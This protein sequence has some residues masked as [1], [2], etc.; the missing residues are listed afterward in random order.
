VDL[1]PEFAAKLGAAFGAL[2]K[3]GSVVTVN[4]DLN[5]TSRMIKRA[6]IAGLPSS[7]VNV[8]DL[9][10][11][12]IPVA[13]YYTHATHAVG[14]VHV[15]L[16]PYDRRVVDIKFFNSEGLT[17]DKQTERTVERI[18]FR[19]DF[20]R[21]YLDDIGHIENA[22]DVSERYSTHFCRSL[23]LPAIRQRKFKLVVDY[24]H[25]PVSLV[26]PRLLNELQCNVIALN[27][28]LDAERMSIPRAEF[29]RDLILL[30]RIT[31]AT[32]ADL[33]VRFDVGGEK[34]FL[35]QADGSVV[36]DHALKAAIAELA[37]RAKPNGTIVVPAH[38]SLALERIAAQHQ[39]R[40][41]RAKL[42]LISL[43]L[44]ATQTGTLVAADGAGG[45]IF[46]EFQA[47]V[48]GLF[49]LAKLLELLAVCN[50][51]LPDV[52][53]AL[54][55]IAVAHRTVSCAWNAKGRVMRLLNE[56]FQAYKS[57][58]VDG[59]RLDLGHEWVLIL[60][61]PDE[62]L[63]HVYAESVTEHDSLRL[64]EKFANLVTELQ[65]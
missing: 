44:A 15:R 26:L 60:P 14:G 18:F 10:N 56:Q 55:P 27:S 33:G 3:V 9:E 36:P 6:I 57:E 31:G 8:M 29:E 22:L 51:T 5:K 47:T 17:I 53:N 43:M 46:P 49:A 16:S 54:P 61:D 38:T 21:V 4:R 64:L 35:V 41:F 32:S 40:V 19:E 63:C 23:N 11:V 34:I 52:L 58:Q 59:L 24:A 12:P 65:K 30:G 37:L 48:D 45:F 7:G 2:H 20:R 28:A 42:D 62:P 1:T 25:S 50:T 13:C 39:G